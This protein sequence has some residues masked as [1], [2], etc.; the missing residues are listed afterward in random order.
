MVFIDFLRVE[1]KYLLPPNSSMCHDGYETTN[2][3][4]AHGVD[5]AFAAGVKEDVV[6]ERS[7]RYFLP[8]FDGIKHAR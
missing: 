5:T 3:S 1:G 7:H 4:M 2:G 6:A 8:G